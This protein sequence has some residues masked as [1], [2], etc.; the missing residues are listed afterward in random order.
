MGSLAR[1]GRWHAFG[2]ETTVAVGGLAVMQRAVACAAYLTGG[3]VAFVTDGADTFLVQQPTASVDLVFAH[4]GPGKFSH[5]EHT[6]RVLGPG[7]R[8]L[9]RELLAALWRTDGG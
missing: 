9:L 6:V 4:T 2:R 7:V 8:C 5:L 3:R 1:N